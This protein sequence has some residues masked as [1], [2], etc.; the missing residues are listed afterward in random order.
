L[1]KAERWEGQR[2]VRWNVMNERVCWMICLDMSLS[3]RM[4]KACLPWVTFTQDGEG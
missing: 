4:R 1:R 2:A 3:S